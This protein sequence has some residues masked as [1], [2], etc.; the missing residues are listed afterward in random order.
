VNKGEI[1]KKS[2]VNVI[3]SHSNI[4]QTRDIKSNG[5]TIKIVKTEDLLNS[6]TFYEGLSKIIVPSFC[7]LLT[8][9][10]FDFFENITITVK[11]LLMS[12][13]LFILM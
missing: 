12:F 9:S 8:Y 2:I 13:L 11:F 5:L 10:C 6:K 7:S 3:G 1:I 4:G